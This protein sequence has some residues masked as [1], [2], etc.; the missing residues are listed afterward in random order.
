MQSLAGWPSPVPLA[1]PKALL[2]EPQNSVETALKTTLPVHRAG[3]PD[4]EVL[5]ASCYLTS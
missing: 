5:L 1:G 3:N 2:S 4:P